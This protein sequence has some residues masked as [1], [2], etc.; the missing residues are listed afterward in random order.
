MK[1]TLEFDLPEEEQ[2]HR[3]ALAGVDAILLVNDLEETI[4][5]LLHSDC[6]YFTEWKNEEGEICEGCPETL[7][8]VWNWIIEQKQERKLPDLI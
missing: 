8:R 3:Y 1:A 2:E 7:Q 6:G 5:E 4:R